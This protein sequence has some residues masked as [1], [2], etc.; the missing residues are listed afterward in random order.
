MKIFPLIFIV[1]FPKNA[2]AQE[3]NDVHFKEYSDAEKSAA[4]KLLEIQDK[5]FNNTGNYDTLVYQLESII[6]QIPDDYVNS[7]QHEGVKYVKFWEEG[8]YE[9]YK[10][11]VNEPVVNLQNAYPKACYF[12]AVIQLERGL[13]NQTLFTL[14]KG[15]KLEPDQPYLLNEFVIMPQKTGQ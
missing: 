13:F 6:S 2:I 4:L 5:L 10:Q 7:F 15:L 14:E 11:I 9:N 3:S 8:E 12:L 1:F